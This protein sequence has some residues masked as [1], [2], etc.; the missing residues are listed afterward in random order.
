MYTA[1]KLYDKLR[2]IYLQLKMIILQKIRRKRL[3]VLKSSQKLV[4]DFV[5]ADL[6]PKPP[7]ERDGIK[8]K[9]KPEEIIA[10][11]LKSNSQERK[12]TGTGLKVLTPNK[13]LTKFP[14]LLSQIK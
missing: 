5:E 6:P 2:Y 10:E 11:G 1:S 12:E 13:F 7:L 9:L 14:M 4:A 3:N 8:V